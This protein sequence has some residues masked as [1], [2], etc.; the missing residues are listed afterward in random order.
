MDRSPRKPNSDLSENKRSW[1]WGLH[2][3]GMTPTE[4]WK[5]T[6]IPRTT[7]SSFISRH[8]KSGSTSFASKPGRGT[9]PKLN[10]RAERQL[11]RIALTEPKMTLE[12]LGSPSK[13]GQKL[14]RHAVSKYL[15]K[16]GKAKR[17]PRK[18][19]YLSPLHKKKR[20]AHSRA[21]LKKKRDPRKVIW[22][23]EVTFEVGADGTTIWV[24]RGPGRE[25]EF[26]EKNLKPT[27]KSGRVAVGAWA[28]FCGDEL[29]PIYIIPEGQTM[30]GRRYKW[31]LQTL[32]VPFYKK[33]ERK[34]GK[35]VVFM[36]DN[37]PWHSHTKA[38]RRYLENKGIRM[39]PH[40]PQSP[41]LNPIE[42]LWKR[43]KAK[44][45][46]RRHRVRNRQE[47]EIAIREEWVDLEQEFLLKLCDSMPRRYEACRKAKGGATKY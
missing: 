29:G 6:G 4:I 30:T 45:S 9:K 47:M 40:P 36:E 41:D 33:M 21:E 11:V 13:S 26:K 46:K 39:M 5:E 19:P 1:I 31:V 23:D 8:T 27:F 15:K 25:E 22:S 24:T 42:N 43:I 17:R 32:L 35:E 38:V 18:K 12:A 34:Y 14:G 20:L 10:E 2:K 28:C 7:I 44:I 16:H 37:A 3:R